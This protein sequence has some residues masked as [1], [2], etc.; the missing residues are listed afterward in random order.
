[1]LLLSGMDN[2]LLFS[3]SG[4]KMI[5][6]RNRRKS[7]T[8][9]ELL[10]VIAI[11]GIFSSLVIA[12]FSNVRDNAKIANTLQWAGGV[13]RSLG[14][15]LIGHWPLNGDVKDISGYENN[16]EIIGDPVWVDSVPGTDGM[17]LE[18][19]GEDDYADTNTIYDF[20]DDNSF[21][22]VVW[23][24]SLDTGRYLCGYR[25]H[26]ARG[27]FTTRGTDGFSVS[28]GIIDNN[29][30]HIVIVYDGS[31]STKYL[32]SF[33]DG[34]NKYNNSQTG[35]PLSSYY[36]QTFIIGATRHSGYIFSHSIISDVRIYDTA[37]TAEEVSR[38]YVE[39]KDK[40]LVEN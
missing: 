11:I 21:T 27:T 16:G 25:Y 35:S 32:K 40:Y 1:M 10:V 28:T 36:A 31:T 34:D 26:L 4:D 29:W 15:N 18:F 22:I 14:A 5:S 2:L 30:H 24:R 6:M 23:S 39:T 20:E 13:H 38:I 8:L 33:A 19:D 9:I 17:A 37:L 12:R 3:L 7:F